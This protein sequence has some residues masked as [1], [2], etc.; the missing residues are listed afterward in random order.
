MDD[1]KETTEPRCP[2]C[3]SENIANQ[4]LSHQVDALPKKTQYLCSDCGF[5]F[6]LIGHPER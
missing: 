3:Q 5:R 6:H 1:Q 2:K 4:G